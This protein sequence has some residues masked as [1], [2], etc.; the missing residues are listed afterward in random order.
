MHIR[1]FVQQQKT[2]GKKSGVGIICKLKCIVSHL[3]RTD[4]AA[5]PASRHPRA[6]ESLHRLLG[7]IC[8]SHR[9]YFPGIFHCNRSRCCRSVCIPYLGSPAALYINY[10]SAGK[11]N[12]F[13]NFLSA[14]RIVVSAVRSWMGRADKRTV[15]LAF[16]TGRGRGSGVGSGSG[17]QRRC[18]AHW[19]QL[20][21][22]ATA[23]AFGGSP[24]SVLSKTARNCC[25]CFAA[26]ARN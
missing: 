26:A 14:A 21:R 8:N 20:R 15:G 13:M 24:A 22:Q 19:R 11:I 18:N 6:P 4:A 3:W 5:L 17:R 25:C 9:I 7:Y 10:I 12:I 1:S 2:A 16:M 23:S